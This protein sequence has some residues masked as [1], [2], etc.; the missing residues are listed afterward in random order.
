VVAMTIMQRREKSPCINVPKLEP[1]ESPMHVQSEIATWFRVVVSKGSA[2]VLSQKM[3]LVEAYKSL[4]I[5]P[6][7][8]MLQCPGSMSVGAHAKCQLVKSPYTIYDV[9]F[10]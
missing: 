5:V 10:I 1:L 6:P 8:S 4:Y 9:G 3:M 2:L 7:L